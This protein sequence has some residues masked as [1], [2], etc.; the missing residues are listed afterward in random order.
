MKANSGAVETS[1]YPVRHDF[2]KENVE[3][4]APHL[5]T[6]MTYSFTGFA[7]PEKILPEF[8]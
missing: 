6:R 4:K 5:S 1:D 7:P 2:F 8:H 3:V